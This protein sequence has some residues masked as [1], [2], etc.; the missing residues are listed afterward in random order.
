MA[1][2]PLHY[3]VVVLGAGYAGLM[4]GVRLSAWS[5]PLRA[6]LI[7]E[8][9]IFTERVRLQES[10]IGA[11]PPRLPPL[12]KWLSDTSLDF[13][14]ARIEGLRAAS[15]IVVISMLGRLH[16]VRFVRCIYALGSMT[17]VD[18]VRGAAEYA[19]RLDPG[20]GPHAAAALRERILNAPVGDHIGVVG[21]RN[22]GVE[23]AAEIKAARPDLAVSIIAAGS[24]GGLGKGARVERAVRD[25]LVK[26]G[27]SLIDDDPVQEVRARDILTKSGRAISA[28]VC[29]WAT[30]L[31]SPAIARA[32]GLAVDESNRIWVDG[33]LRSISHPSILAVGDAARPLVP[34]GATYRQ[35]AL[36][37]LA[38]G[39]Y[40][41][42]SLVR[43]VRGKSP[44]P[45]SFA[46]YG[47]G[48]A[49]GSVGVG[50]VTYP[51]DGQGYFVVTGGLALRLRN[52][53]V[54]V[55]IWCLRI[56]RF[57]PGLSPFWIGRRRVSWTQAD[58]FAAKA[59]DL[60]SPKRTASSG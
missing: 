11:V 33:A 48:V 8:S 45:F 26:L 53:F 49:I 28:D 57:W 27:V 3:D 30:G 20:D 51:D 38:S 14:Q 24:A 52:L 43:E 55:L 35:S 60:S 36:A 58:T 56:E 16:S 50:F 12:G 59:P 37:A 42:R 7:S 40:A 6:L 10:L 13:L 22:T 34:A 25:Q 31:R 1:E 2:H 47:Q 17:D 32:A 46:A 44:R 39:A 21:G 18:T 9:E 5:C 29:V 23:A 41:A 54:R 19:F 15:G 4:A